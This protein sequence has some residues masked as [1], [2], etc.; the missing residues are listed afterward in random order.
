V[1]VHPRRRVLGAHE[2]LP[3]PDP[4]REV[5]VLVELADEVAA[6]PQVAAVVVQQLVVADPVPVLVGLRRVAEEPVHVDREEPLVVVEEQVRAEPQRRV[7][8]VAGRKADVGV[9]GDAHDALGERLHVR[10]RGRA[11]VAAVERPDPVP[12]L[13]VAL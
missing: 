10:R 4:A 3:E 6:G 13:E 7:S 8:E 12:P 5:D 1:D 2:V 11:V 9:G